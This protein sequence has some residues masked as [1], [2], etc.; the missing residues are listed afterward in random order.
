L[1]LDFAGAQAVIHLGMPVSHEDTRTNQIMDVLRAK[2]EFLA[3][4]ILANTR[5][6]FFSGEKLA[7]LDA[8]S[9]G[10]L[11]E[12]RKVPTNSV[13]LPVANQPP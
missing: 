12:M 4:T 1:F 13:G 7:R 5:R 10:I 8:Q 9:G 6:L 3:M 2:T 11:Y